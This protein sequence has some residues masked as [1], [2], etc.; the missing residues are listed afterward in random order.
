MNK[1]IPFLFLLCVSSF[2]QTQESKIQAVLLL[3]FAENVKWAEDKKEL[4]IGI[5]GKTDVT[6][7]LEQRLKVRNP[8]GIVLKKITA[9]EAASCDVVYVPSSSANNLNQI[10]GSIGFKPVLVVTE[11]DYTRKGSCIS[12]IED[13]GKMHFIINKAVIEARGLKV[14][15]ALL[16]LGKQV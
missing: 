9:A 15:S 7:E 3:K 16:N 11:T 1:L 2:G 14:S 10:T 4:I 12:I 8:M 13:E 5:V 6:P